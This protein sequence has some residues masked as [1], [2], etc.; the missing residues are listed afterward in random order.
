MPWHVARNVH[1]ISG[2]M[3]GWVRFTTVNLPEVDSL[4]VHILAAVAESVGQ[5]LIVLP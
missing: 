1:F 4:M 3:E 5:W 2:L